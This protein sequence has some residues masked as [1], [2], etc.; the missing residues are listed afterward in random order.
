MRKVSKILLNDIQ[1]E[2]LLQILSM[3]E[4]D[5]MI[6]VKEDGNVEGYV[7]VSNKKFT[8]YYR[9]L[10]GEFALDR[11]LDRQD[12]LEIEVRDGVSGIL[13]CRIPIM[14]YLIERFARA[15]Y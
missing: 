3:F 4:R 9:G 2:D 6:L 13:N 1:L 11:I 5:F 14:G 15:G 10:R 7:A 12:R 8:A